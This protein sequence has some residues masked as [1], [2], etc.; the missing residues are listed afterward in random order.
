MKLSHVIAAAFLTP[1]LLAGEP[2]TLKLPAERLRG[3]GELAATFTAGDPAASSLVISCENETK[4]GIVLAKFVSDLHLL[5]GIKDDTVEVAGIRVPVFRVPHQGVICAFRDGRFVS[6]LA[7]PAAD[8]LATGLAA[9]KT[10]LAGAEM[11][12]LQKIWR[13]YS[14][15]DTTIEY[16]EPHGELRHGEHDILTEYGPA[17]DRSYRDFL[18]QRHGDLK[19]LSQRW[20]DGT[21]ESW[22]EV[23]ESLKP[24]E[25]L[26]ALRLPQNFL[27]YRVYLT[28]HEPVQYPYLGESLNAQ[29]VDFIRWQ[30]WTR[31]ESCRRSFEAIREVDPDRSVVCMAP[32]AFMS[33]MEELC[34][35]YGG[36]FHNTGYM[37]GWWAEQ[38]PMMMRAADLPVRRSRADRRAR[39]RSSRASSAIGS[40]RGSTAT[41]SSSIWTCMRTI[42]STPSAC[43]ISLAVSPM[44]TGRSW[45]LK[46]R[47][48]T[49]SG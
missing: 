44:A 22:T 15:L 31:Q 4:A 32:D 14:K 5:G 38:L 16:L 34:Q 10:Q 29:W 27:G 43:A 35:D 2:A 21:L 28:G 42:I 33:G 41:S 26:L 3:Y 45:T 6:I 19:T 37:A 40:P 48:S 36:H 20:H 18:K 8:A 25:N 24:G 30:A 13:D 46:V 39:S 47:F 17:A 12:V 23:T 11:S 7:S 9:C 49:R 1:G